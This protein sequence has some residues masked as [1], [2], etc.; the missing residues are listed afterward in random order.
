MDTIADKIKQALQALPH[1]RLEVSDDSH[2]HIGHAGN[3]DGKG[4][5]H[6]SV[7]IVSTSFEG[8]SRVARQR[9]VLD[10]V[11]PL[12]GNTSLHAFSIRA[13]TPAEYL[14]TSA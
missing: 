3:P 11:A 4:Q 9:M 8:L 7:E 1:T 6:F 5:T 14:E 2:H 10:R 13:L 12:W